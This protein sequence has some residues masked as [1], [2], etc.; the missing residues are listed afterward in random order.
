MENYFT[1]GQVPPDAFVSVMLM[2]IVPKHLN[3]IKQYQ[4][5]GYFEFREKRSRSLMNST[6]R[7]RTSMYYRPCH[8]HAKNRYQTTCFARVY[9]SS[10]HIQT[11]RTLTESAFFVTSFLIGLYDR[12]LAASLDVARIQNAA[13]AEQLAVE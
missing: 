12:Q 3:E 13:D 10:K 9:W 1:I 7:R 4:S 6:W 8:R 2:K 11:S 5:L